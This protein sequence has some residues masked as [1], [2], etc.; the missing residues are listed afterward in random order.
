MR[1]ILVETAVSVF[2]DIKKCIIDLIIEIIKPNYYF[3]EGIK[4]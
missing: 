2:V 1:D 3:F 4:I